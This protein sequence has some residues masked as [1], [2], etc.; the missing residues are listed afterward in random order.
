MELWQNA[1]EATGAWLAVEPRMTGPNTRAVGAW[2]EV[3]TEAGV[4][5]REVTVGGGHVGGQAG[6]IHFGL[7][8]ATAAEVRVLWPGGV[9]SDWTEVPVNARIALTP[10][11][12]IP[13]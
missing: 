7:G 9:W 4:Q 10:E 12:L 8:P 11:G 2:I 3:R 1:T 6:P 5:T 13:G